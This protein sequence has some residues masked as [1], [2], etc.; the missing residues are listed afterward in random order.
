MMDERTHSLGLARVAWAT[1]WSTL[2]A[3][4]RLVDVRNDTYKGKEIECKQ[5]NTRQLTM[6][7]KTYLL[8]QWWL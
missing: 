8:Q 4:E 6:K 5:P 1:S 2:L 7:N 3:N